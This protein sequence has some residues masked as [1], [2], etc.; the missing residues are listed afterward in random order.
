MPKPMLSRDVTE[1]SHNSFHTANNM[2]GSDM[3]P[4]SQ[5][6]EDDENIAM[7]HDEVEDDEEDSMMAEL[8]EQAEQAAIA[9]FGE[10]ADVPLDEAPPRR[11]TLVSEN[12]TIDGKFKCVDTYICLRLV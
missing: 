6:E 8:D 7:A 9:C 2:R 3:H 4:S 11:S 1:S 12:A 10:E 5:F